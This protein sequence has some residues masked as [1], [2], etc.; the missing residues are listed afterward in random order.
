MKYKSQTEAVLA[1]L[2][3]KG[4]ITS[5]EAERLYGAS[6]LSGLIYVLRR[7]GYKIVT[8]PFKVTTRYGTTSQPARYIL[9]EENE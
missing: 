1:H 4:H 2:K 3:E 5:R 8:E 7:R 6:R 9:H